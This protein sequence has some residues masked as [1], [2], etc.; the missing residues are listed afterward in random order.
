[1]KEKAVERRNLL[2]GAT[3]KAIVDKGFDSV[4]LQD[5]ADYSGVSK[6]VTSYYFKNK[7]DVFYHLFIWITERIYQNEKAAVDASAGALDKLK[8]YVNVAFLSPKKNKE[9]FKVYLEFLAYATRN[10]SFREINQQFYQNCWKIG[11]EIVTLGQKESTISS[12]IDV[13]KAAVTIRSLIDG[14][15]IQWS[16]RDQDEL[17]E[18]YRNSCYEAIASYLTNETPQKYLESTTMT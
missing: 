10:Q 4:T 3:F 6:G 13:E 9:F 8:A 16:M 18:Y 17:H 12:S 2:L 5:I 7:E 14:C 1:M 11:R 15:L